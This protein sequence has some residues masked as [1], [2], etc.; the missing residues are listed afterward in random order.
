M[1]IV[2]NEDW[3]FVS[4]R[5]HLGVAALEA[6]Y[7]VTVATRVSESREVIER[8]GMAVVPIDVPRSVSNPW[9]EAKAL[10]S[11][12]R[13]YRD[14][15]PDLVHHVVLKNVL[16]GSLAARLTGVPAVVNAITGLAHTFTV[17]DWKCRLL[18]PTVLRALRFALS[19]PNSCVVLQNE[20]D[21]EVLVRAGAVRRER[22]VVICSAGVDVQTYRP[23]PLPEWRLDG[24]SPPIVV[25][26][27]RMLW[28][29]GV[30]EFVEAARQLRRRGIRAR[31]VLVGRVDTG[32]PA[33]VPE[34]Q[35][36][37][38]VSEGVV[39][40]WGHC[41]NMP[42]VLS[43]AAVVCLPSY[44]REGAPKV[45]LEAAA[46]GRPVVTTDWVGCRDVVDPG[47]SAVLVPPRDPDALANA[48]QSLL[49]DRDRCAELGRNGR[50][51]VVQNFTQE[52]IAERTLDVYATLL[53]AAGLPVPTPAVR[54]AA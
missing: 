5:L 21:R 7:R 9:S 44:Y 26:P 46:C 33:H 36:R 25:L 11:L 41:T 18:R 17:D 48:L 12:V 35:L 45:L 38:W 54:K 34:L 29:K 52:L 39:E 42:R 51:W 23:S 14:I 27:S 24:D 47:R 43:Q 40:W 31:F 32:N 20:S 15:R 6:G 4:H 22:A 37:Q 8:H 30:G 49:Q 1:L 53:K 19:L 2:V 13:I 3:F 28:T 50:R 16:Y 10:L